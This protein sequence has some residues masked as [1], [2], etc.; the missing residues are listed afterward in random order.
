[1]NRD[2]VAVA[3]GR[4]LRT[5]RR[6]AHISREEVVQA[7]AFKRTQL[8]LIE[9]GIRAPTITEVLALAKAIKADP[10]ELIRRTVFAL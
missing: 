5:A 7:F 1:M 10:A 6:E 8:S 3:F 4:V 2:P 9:R